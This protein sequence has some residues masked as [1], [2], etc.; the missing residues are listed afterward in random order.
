MCLR[1]SV[2]IGGGKLMIIGRASIG[3]EDLFDSTD[4]R[5]I[6]ANWILK[7]KDP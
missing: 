2:W 5:R 4:I 7:V 3:F 6:L 1:A